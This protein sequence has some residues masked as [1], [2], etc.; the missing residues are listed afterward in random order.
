M[1]RRYNTERKFDRMLRTAERKKIVIRDISKMPDDP[2]VEMLER[3]FVACIYRNRAFLQ[4][5]ISYNAMFV[6]SNRT[7]VRRSG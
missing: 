2:D 1:V 5:V 6:P 4:T 7:R 3:C